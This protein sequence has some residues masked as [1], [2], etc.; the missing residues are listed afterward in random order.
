[1][2]PTPTIVATI[3]WSGRESERREARLGERAAKVAR[4]QAAEM[5]AS[6]VAAAGPEKMAMVAEACT[7]EVGFVRFVDRAQRQHC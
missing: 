6:G 1:M 5:T 7:P 4:E 2:Q 3:Q